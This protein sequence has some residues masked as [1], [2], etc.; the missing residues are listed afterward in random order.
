M[1]NKVGT[2]PFHRPF[3]LPLKER[4]ELDTKLETILDSRFL[5]NGEN[6]HRFEEAIKRRYPAN[7]VAACSSGTLALWIVLLGLR[8]AIADFGRYG[9][10]AL[11]A[12]VQAFTW[13]SIIHLPGIVAFMDIEPDTWLLR[14]DPPVPAPV[15]IATHTFGNTFQLDV[16]DVRSVYPRTRIVYDAAESFGAKIPDFGEA[17]VFSFSPTKTITCMEGGAIVTNDLQLYNEI[18]SLRNTLSRMSEIHA[19]VGLAYLDHLEEIMER[20]R[21]IA[22]YYR[23]RLPLLFTFQKIATDHAYGIFGT[24][25]NKEVNCEEL[26]KKL[27]EKGLETRAYYRPLSPEFKTTNDI[28]ER[29]LCLPCYPSLDERKVVETIRSV[30]EN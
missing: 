14:L 9:D 16:A 15:I 2:V 18:V 30:V 11:M 7:Y 5:T 24:L 1:D 21:Q 13:S 3:K 10:F 25:V 29:M 22:D 17:T 12:D 4:R 19:A 23:A 28:Y 20:K 27:A 8:N 26:R 6:V